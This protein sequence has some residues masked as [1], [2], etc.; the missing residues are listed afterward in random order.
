MDWV[1]LWPN[2]RNYQ[3]LLDPKEPG[4]NRVKEVMLFKKYLL[5]VLE[6]LFIPFFIFNS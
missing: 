5:E 1:S 6:L 2:F 3:W 4:A